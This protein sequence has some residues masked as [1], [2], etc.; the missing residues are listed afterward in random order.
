MKVTKIIFTTALI[1]LCTAAFADDSGL[2]TYSD[3]T[4]NP[5]SEKN[6]ATE[7]TFTLPLDSFVDVNSWNTVNTGIFTL[8]GAYTSNNT[9]DASLAKSFKNVYFGTYFYDNLSQS[10]SFT[11]TTTVESTNGATTIDNEY[12]VSSRPV[13]D[14]KFAFLAGWKNWGFKFNMKFGGYTRNDGNTFGGFTDSIE[15]NNSYAGTD[16]ITNR[17]FLSI[18]PM[19][20]AGTAFSVNGLT[21]IPHALFAVGFDPKETV[22]KSTDALGNTTTTTTQYYTYSTVNYLSYTRLV[23]GLGSG[24]DFGGSNTFKQSA[25]A[26]VVATVYLFPETIES[27]TNTNSSDASETT[28]TQNQFKISLDPSY[29]FEAAVTDTVSINGKVKLPMQVYNFSHGHTTVTSTTSGV[30]TTTYDTISDYNRTVFFAAPSLAL[31]VSHALTPDK[32]FLN[33]G[34]SIAMSS[35]TL[36]KIKTVYDRTASSSEENT[37]YSSTV[38]NDTTKTENLDMAFSLGFTY[39]PFANLVIDTA[40]TVSTVNPSLGTFWSNCNF[41]VQGTIRF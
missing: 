20:E 4:V 11:D 29:T 3:L 38:E 31:G 33:Y 24:I 1:A 37:N 30:T 40:A 41:A 22:I 25:N 16:V 39:Q 21:V 7:G 9:I 12:I 6:N 36:E 26:D 34:V 28:I 14:I 27:K 35:F 5:V 10:S 19:L 15:T 17:N 13:T 18:T 2:V 32:F 23:F 8:E